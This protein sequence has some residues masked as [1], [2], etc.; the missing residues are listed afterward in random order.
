MYIQR[1]LEKKLKKYYKLPEI[2]AIIG[3]RQAGK[4][5]LI[6]KFLKN[7]PKVKL[8]TLEDIDTKTLFEEDIKGFKKRYENYQT[9]FID[10]IQYAKNSGKQLKYLFDTTKQKIIVSGSSTTELSLQSIKYLVGR[11]ITLELHTLSFEEF[12]TYKDKE[13][14]KT[15]KTSNTAIKEA[16]KYL[17]EYILYGGYPRVVLEKDPETKKELIKNIYN[18]YLLKEI[19]E[20]LEFKKSNEMHKIIQLLALQT[21]NL[22]RIDDI[23][24]KANLSFHETKQA[25]NILE[26]TYIITLAR[27]TYTNKQQEIVKTPKLFFIDTGLCNHATQRFAQPITGS[28]YENYVAGEIIRAERELKYWR[29]K[30]QAEVD[31]IVQETPIEVKKTIK[32]PKIERSLHAYIERYK[33]EKA[34]ILSQELNDTTTIKNTSIQFTPLV[35]LPDI[36]KKIH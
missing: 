9:I 28:L 31:F 8:L 35:K 16:N 14:L 17:E 18:T 13:L 20:I 25:L 11:V 15:I 10:E 26:K 3:P 27:P 29:S 32:K 33:P 5:T 6:Q 7:K 1:T 22:L 21:S 19:R 24:N 2:L 4:T 23:A 30:G 12:L 36:L 34:I